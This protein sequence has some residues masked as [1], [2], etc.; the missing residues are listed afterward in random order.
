MKKTISLFAALCLALSLCT[1]SSVPAF[2]QEQTKDSAFVEAVALLNNLGIFEAVS[3]EDAQ[4]TLTRAEYAKVI[5][6]VMDCGTLPEQGRRIF[7]DVL[8]EHNASASIEYL[9]DRD[10]MHGY[11][12]AEF[13]PDSV[14]TLEEAVKVAVVVIGYNQQAEWDGGWSTGYYYNAISND[15]MVGVQ[16]GWQD[17]LTTANAAILIRNILENNTFLEVVGYEGDEPIIQKAQNKSYMENVLGVYLFKG[18]V[19]AAG[20]TDLSGEEAELGDFCR[21]GGKNFVLNGVNAEQYLGMKVRA[22]YKQDALE[23]GFLLHLAEDENRVLEIQAE[24]IIDAETDAVSYYEGKKEKRAGIAEDAVFLYNGK[25]LPVVTAEDMLPEDG[26]VILISNDGNSAYDVVMIRSYNTFVV[27]KVMAA[28]STLKFKYGKGSLDLKE[29]NGITA[30]YFMDG[31]EAEF[32]AITANSVLSVG[33][34]K[35]LSGEILADI[36]ISNNQVT[37]SVKKV[38]DDG[39]QRRVILSDDKTY[40]FT[41]E[42]I[43]RLN[44][45][46]SNSYM[47]AMGEDGVF[48][49]DYFG[50]LAAYSVSVESKNYAY[51]IASAYEETVEKGQLKLFTKEGEVKIFELGKKVRLNGEVKKPGEVIEMLSTSGPDGTV[52]QVVVYKANSEEKITE[53]KIAEKKTSDQYYVAAEDEFVLNGYIPTNLRFY[54]DMAENKPYCFVANQTVRFMIPDDKSREQ[55]YKVATKLDTTDVTL[56]GPLYIYDAGSAGNI[57][58]IVTKSGDSGSYS[59]SVVINQVLQVL[60]EEGNV[61]TGLELAGGNTITLAEHAA[62]VQSNWRCTDKEF[63]YSTETLAG[64]RRGDVIQY[65]TTNGKAD[66]IKLIVKAENIGPIRIDGDHIQRSGNMIA[67]ILSV[68]KNG[69]TAMVRYSN[70]EGEILQTMLVNGSVFRYD[71]EEDEVTS[72]STADLREGDKVLINSFWWSPKAVVIFR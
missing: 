41:K 20:N 19:E 61:C 48:Y 13:R 7:T 10:V 22:Y 4:K 39:D 9:Y 30:R 44:E 67:E 31:A 40:M 52:N 12:G 37:G 25:R 64:L 65:A 18:V 58:A 53:L 34:S 8:P 60:D 46:E 54:K 69:R 5:A 50:K 15:L 3:T 68:S 59:D 26:S 14:I 36:Y 70:K 2:G 43:N 23:R 6:R 11:G 21:I 63:S 56:I 45:G 28:D 55:D 17:E 47:P 24:D 62:L 57:G 33:L 38:Y 66:K 27:E 35:N 49:I 1:F 32:S 72:S 16:G 51:L 29:G 42:F 71:S